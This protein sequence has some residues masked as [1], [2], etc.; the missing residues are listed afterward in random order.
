MS[1]VKFSFDDRLI[2]SWSPTCYCWILYGCEWS[3]CGY[4]ILSFQSQQEKV[5]IKQITQWKVFQE[6]LSLFLCLF[7]VRKETLFNYLSL[8]GECEDQK[9]RSGHLGPYPKTHNYL[10]CWFFDKRYSLGCSKTTWEHLLFLFTLIFSKTNT[11]PTKLQASNVSFIPH[12]SSLLRRDLLLF[13]LPYK[14]FYQ[15]TFGHH[16]LISL[17]MFN[18]LYIWNSTFLL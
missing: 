6:T 2:S 18:V 12:L 13:F 1:Q 7:T 3:L 14:S 15:L 5:P 16:P 17:F 8:A 11:N 4:Y 10:N 9:E